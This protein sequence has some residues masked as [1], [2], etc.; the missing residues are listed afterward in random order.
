MTAFILDSPSSPINEQAFRVALFIY[1]VSQQIY[2]KLH[3]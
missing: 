3:I 1:I 2:K